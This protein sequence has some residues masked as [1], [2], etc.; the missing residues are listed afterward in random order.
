[1]SNV[2]SSKPSAKNVNSTNHL[3]GK[4][5]GNFILRLNWN[6][7]MY[8][9]PCKDE[10]VRLY[11]IEQRLMRMWQRYGKWTR[12]IYVAFLEHVREESFNN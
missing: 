1:M 11:E 2:I 3:P 12:L 10:E 4:T 7:L 5:R 8:I 9:V 6:F